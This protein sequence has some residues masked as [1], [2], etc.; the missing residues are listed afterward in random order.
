MIY[1]LRTYDTTPGRT[2]EYIKLHVEEALPRL[3]RFLGEPVGYWTTEFGTLN[4]LVHL[5]RYESLADLER[6]FDELAADGG[7]GAY[8]DKIG[9]LGLVV[10]QERKVLRALPFSNLR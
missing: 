7:W 2:A 8:R 10:K 9:R 4:Q 3:R 1:E 6:R 5:W